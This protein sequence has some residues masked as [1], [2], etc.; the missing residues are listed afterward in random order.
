MFESPQTCSESTRMPVGWQPSSTC[1]CPRLFLA[2]IMET[3]SSTITRRRRS[4]SRL[5]LS[6]WTRNATRPLSHIRPRYRSTRVGTR[7]NFEI[8]EENPAKKKRATTNHRAVVAASRCSRGFAL[9]LYLIYG[10]WASTC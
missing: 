5:I 9:C 6:L 2:Y 3:S 1:T 4:Q 7:S 10:R 8:L